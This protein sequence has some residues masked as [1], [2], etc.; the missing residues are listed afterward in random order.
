MPIKRLTPGA[1]TSA[2]KPVVVAGPKLQL[3]L[4]TKV[5]KP[6]SSLSA[7]SML[8]YGSKKIGKTTLAARFPSAYF[9]S[10]EPGTKALKV[11]SS[12]CPSWDHLSGYAD[13][14]VA[15]NDPGQTV[16]VDVID[17]AYEMIYDKICRQQKIESP[18][19]ENDYGATWRKIRRTFRELI[20]KLVALPGGCIFLSHDTEKEIEL[21]NGD[22]VDRVQP[23]MGKQALQEVEGIVDFIGYYGYEDDERFLWIRGKQT[24]VA[25]CRLGEYH[26]FFKTTAGEDVTRIPM[27]SSSQEA[28]DNLLRAFR[29]QQ[30]TPTGV[31]D[32]KDAVVKPRLSLTTKG[33]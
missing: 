31:T 33:K 26:D 19:D 29:N 16:V 32:T 1:S 5:N 18:T 27:G 22:K 4:Q 14:L 15:A 23:T 20:E 10:T 13:L 30:V 28:Y 6:P 11:L 8:I 2:A 9:L 24:M 21:R 3:S 7:Y 12:S 25:G 17:L